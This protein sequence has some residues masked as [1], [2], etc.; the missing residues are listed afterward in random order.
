LP[1]GLLSAGLAFFRSDLF[2]F[3]GIEP[4]AAAVWTF[5]HFDAPFAAEKMPLELD[6]VAAGTF[7]FA[8][9]I[10]DRVF[11]S[12]DLKEHLSR[13][14]V[15]F[16]HALKFEGIK[17]DAAAATLANVHYQSADLDLGQFI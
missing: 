9:R 1:G 12:L 16:I 4:I 3:P 7:P 11:L 10:E 13:S 6:A 5:I 15:F 17:P 14:L 2:Q 8:R